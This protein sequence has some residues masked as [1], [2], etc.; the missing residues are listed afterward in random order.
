MSP[1]NNNN[2][3][4][5]GPLSNCYVV[6]YH[7]SGDSFSV[8]SLQDYLTHAHDAFLNGRFFDSIVLAI[9]P[10]EQGARDECSVWQ[11]RRDQ[12]PVSAH[13]RLADLKR[14]IEGLETQL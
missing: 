11:D 13:K 5:T 14:Y 4:D 7:F 12:S 6:E 10:S 2:N 9:H 1:N 8:N 3:A